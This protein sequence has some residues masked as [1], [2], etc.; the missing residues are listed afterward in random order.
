M[1]K[2]LKQN[3]LYCEIDKIHVKQFGPRIPK[4]EAQKTGILYWVTSNT[5]QLATSYPIIKMSKNI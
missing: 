2:E 1:Y 4:K 3:F 5:S